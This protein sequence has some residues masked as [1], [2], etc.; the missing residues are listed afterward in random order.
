MR[1]GW[2]C[3]LAVREH[4]HALDRSGARVLYHNALDPT[5]PWITSTGPDLCILHTTFLCARWYEDFDTYRRRFRWVSTL[6]CPKI[7]LPQD[8]YDHAAVLDEWLGELGVTSVYS[9]FGP[10]RRAVL[11]PTL[12]NRVPFRETLTG[13]LD[14]D[15]AAAL[16]GRLVPHAQRRFDVVYRATKLP[17]WFGSHGQ[18][19]H[20][21]A[22]AVQ[23]RAAEVGL[24]T[25]ISTRW[26]DT[27]FGGGWLDF[28]MSGRAVIGS[29][30]GSSV[31][32]ERGEIQWRIRRLLEEEPN[33][34]FEEVD[35]RMPPGWDSY[36]FFAI[37]PRHLEAV[38]TKTAQVL[39]EGRYSGV[40]RPH[41]HY[42]PLRSD[43]S[44]LNDA[45]ERL[46]DVEAVEAMTERA[47]RDI[48][49]SGRH[50]LA[51]FAGRL[52]G[53]AEER[54][55][56]R[57]TVPFALA[58]RLPVVR[59]PESPL[60]GARRLGR[61]ALLALA[62]VESVLRQ[63][64]DVARTLRAARGQVPLR[65]VA[66]D[67]I[68]LRALAHMRSLSVEHDAGTVVIRTLPGP[69]DRRELKVDG[70]IDRVIWEHSGVTHDVP[71]FPQRPSW[72]SL[73][74]DPDGKYEFEALGAAAR[75]DSGA[76]RALLERA[77]SS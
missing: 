3:G 10:A 71:L 34:S 67:L 60:P 13:F 22:E 49:L 43:F 47:Y 1:R 48:Y 40:L 32:D 15:A 53:E 31:L 7:A 8:E 66:R 28:L 77:L 65:N 72:G 58:T 39:V 21:I 2:T 44:N 64:K 59:M 46:R 5:P 36:S 20:R 19:K 75:T 76:T 14:E 26:E 69:P 4:L 38:M 35:A 25:D 63:P 56:P 42:I 45:L 33:L 27:I 11:Y 9:C 54:R 29:E 55:K 23:A 74:L 18:L 62:F 30:S 70:P 57:L 52:L 37:S 17:Y 6:D 41:E 73:A 68:R 16:A 51:A 12:H 50:N 24:T 61:Q